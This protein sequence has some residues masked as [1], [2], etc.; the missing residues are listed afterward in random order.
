VAILS[1][2]LSALR[3]GQARVD[4]VDFGRFRLSVDPR[5]AGGAQYQDPSYWAELVSPL[6]QGIVRRFSPE[7]FVDVGANYGFTALVHHSLNPAARIRR[8]A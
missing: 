6:E 2:L 7:L 3:R 5:D 4:S 8:L 1:H